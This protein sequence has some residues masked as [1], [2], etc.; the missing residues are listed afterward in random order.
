MGNIREGRP[1]RWTL[2]TLEDVSTIVPSVMATFQ[3]V[4]LPYIERYSNLR[5]AFEAL[6]ANDRAS[7]LHSPFHGERCRQIVALAFLLG[8]VDQVDGII[9]DCTRFLKDRND[10]ELADF[11][12]FAEEI[13][14]L[15]MARA[16][17]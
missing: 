12:A 4:G 5:N 10:P 15:A 6:K 9:Q 13:R 16:R 14:R 2:A 17:S 8:K 11:L 1:K 3:E 7:W